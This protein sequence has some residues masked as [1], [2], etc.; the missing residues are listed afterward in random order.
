M[1][2]MRPSRILRK[3][4]NGEPVCTF[5]LNSESPRIAEMTATFGFDGLWLCNEHTGND[6]Q[7]NENMIRAA[8]LSDVDTIVRVSR[9][10][11][12]DYVRPLEMDAT[13]IM[14]PH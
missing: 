1:I 5:K 13:G 2:K 14:V 11:Y 10:S 3:L 12:S 6:W 9:G 8:K 4:R 7:T